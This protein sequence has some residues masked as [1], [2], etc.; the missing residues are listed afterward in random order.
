[1]EDL[2][3]RFL[4]VYKSLPLPIRNLVGTCYEWVPQNWRYGA[5]YSAYQ[6]RLKKF[7]QFSPEQIAQEQFS[8]LIHAVSHA[9]AH[10]PFYLDFAPIQSLAEF[11]QL[12]ILVKKDLV[13]RLPEFSDA[14]RSHEFL[15][16]NTGGSSGTP[17]TFYLHRNRTR[18]KEKAQFDWYWGQFGYTE[19]APLLM[20]RGTP[21]A[22][23][24]LFEYQAI[25]NKLS[26]SCYEINATNV[27]V[28]IAEINRFKPQFI[29][30]YPS[31]LR[32]L[33][34]CIGNAER[35]SADVHFKAAFLGS[36]YLFDDDR[37]LFA[38][39]YRTR[40]VNWYGHSECLVLGGNCP[41]SDEYHFY[42]SYGYLELLDDQGNDITVPGTEGR[43]VCTGFDNEVMPFIRYDTEDRGV[44]S[45]HKTCA[46]G[47]VGISLSKI[48][49][50]GKD[51]ILLT[52][53][54][55][56]SLTAFIYG[57]HLAEFAKIVE[58]Q[59][60][61]N[62]VGK[63]LI[64]IVRCENYTA[65][66][67]ASLRNTLLKSV[68]GKLAIDFEYVDVIPKTHRGKHRFL[69]SDIPGFD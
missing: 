38:E 10:I 37:R 13:N 39:F 46:C 18:P 4:S 15:T 65:N 69:I 35:L 40:V 20:V 21:L 16:A 36:E 54:T 64:R 58:M 8:L 11:K 2:L 43:I 3:Y 28:V 60:Q 48:V 31:A 56:V 33:T 51:R 30:A 50:R 26:V 47:F 29:H 7:N 25:G 24:A 14:S 42:P 34:N 49:G 57:Q 68:S 44:L 59:L 61:Q 23:N 66:D 1:M 41:V 12:P 22:N 5:F 9:I 62:E 19:N 6:Q 63:L 67:E 55:E 27:A 32:I 53:G 17:L 52:D 45:A